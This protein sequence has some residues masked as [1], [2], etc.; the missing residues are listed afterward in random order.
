MPQNNLEIQ[1]VSS[2]VSFRIEVDGTV[3]PG[4]EIAE[5]AVEGEH[6]DPNAAWIEFSPDSS[7]ALSSVTY[8]NY[9]G[10]V[11]AFDVMSGD[12]NVRLNGSDVTAGQIVKHYQHG[13]KN[14]LVVD[15]ADGV[16]ANYTV[17]VS[18]QIY[19]GSGFGSTDQNQMGSSSATDA[20]YGGGWSD[21]YYTGEVTGLDVSGDVTLYN[22][23]AEVTRD[24]LVAQPPSADYTVSKDFLDVTFDA[25]PSS[26]GTASI[27]SYA[28]TIGGQSRSGQMVT[29]SFSS[30][31]T[32][33]VSLT[34]TDANGNSDT[35]SGTVTVDE[36]QNPP[37]A[38]FNVTST[39]L[40]ATFDANET[41]AG[42]NPIDE[43]AWT[44]NGDQ[45]YGESVT[46]TM[47]SAGTYNAELTVTDTAGLSD[48]QR[49]SFSVTAPP[50][51]GDGGLGSEMLLLGGLGIGAIVLADDENTMSEVLDYDDD[52]ILRVDD[53]D[54]IREC[55]EENQ[56]QSG[57]EE[58]G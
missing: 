54:E 12:L 44:I 13:D 16:T 20:L 5:Y 27:S 53:L 49:D 1:A 46:V 35:K 36:Q 50:D 30:A 6:Y 19:A 8:W 45:Y 52:D 40:E 22:N 58:S 11:T 43:Y 38:L 39:N 56:P 26:P 33:D 7:Y 48:T 41:D 14:R 18:G 15:A 9:D 37:T 47:P 25:S 17:E 57:G 24:D 32:Y 3:S 28:W 23:C 21:V 29:R 42:S 4:E 10:A 34:V 2:D 51:D 31:G 55:V